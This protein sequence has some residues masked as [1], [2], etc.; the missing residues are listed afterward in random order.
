MLARILILNLNPQLTYPDLSI[1][2]LAT[3]LRA[4]GYHVEVQHLEPK[5]PA[6]QS[7]DRLLKDN[8]SWPALN[9]TNIRK[10]LENTQPALILIPNYSNQYAS[11]QVLADLAQQLQLPLLLG[12]SCLNS[13]R[14]EDLPLWLKLKGVTAVFVGEADW[15]IADVVDTVL[16]KQ[17]LSV[18]P[19]IYQ[20]DVE[21]E[22]I[23]APA[24]QE[25]ERLPI[26]D[27]SDF[28]W[29]NC[30]SALIP[31]LTGRST[32]QDNQRKVYSA[33]PV[34]A[35][36][37]ELTSQAALYQRKDFI[38]LDSSLNANLAM[39]HGLIDNLQHIVPGCSWVSTLYLDGHDAL[40]LDLN[41]LVAARAA[42]LRHLTISL[43]PSEALKQGKLLNPTLERNRELVA[44]AYQ[45]GLS[46]RCLVGNNNSLNNLAD[47]PN[48]SDFL[49]RKLV[50]TEQIK[51]TISNQV[52]E[53]LGQQSKTPTKLNKTTQTQPSHL[54]GSSLEKTPTA[55]KAAPSFWQRFKL[56]SAI[57]KT[58]KRKEVNQVV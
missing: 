6:N 37:E 58:N 35:V 16:N 34:Q 13:C 21:L 56:Q 28:P 50:E 7:T 20:Q 18:W 5:L 17:D 1:A 12:G 33:R 32:F 38:F 15:V 23:A 22:G 29:K 44:R 54:T 27:L 47:L 51:Q 46:V 43:E 48:T 40:G 49:L 14:S 53:T 57:N 9:L 25:L 3:P 4:A 42:G 31:V 45:A 30:T 10:Y 41:T 26:P 11:V 36:L 2:Y 8:P 39:W 24:L 19:G 52:L 55:T